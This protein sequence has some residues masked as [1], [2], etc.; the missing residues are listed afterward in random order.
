MPE[1]MLNITLKI[2][3]KIAIATALSGVL[4]Q[5]LLLSGKMPGTRDLRI[6]DAWLDDAAHHVCRDVIIT[7]TAT[8]T[9]STNAV[10]NS[11]VPIMIG[12]SRLLVVDVT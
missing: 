10:A 11:A 7:S 4:P 1:H 6:S 8:F 9:S 2:V 3:R 5:L 12:T